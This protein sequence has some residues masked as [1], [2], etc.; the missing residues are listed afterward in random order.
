M[1]MYGN[2]PKTNNPVE[3]FEYLVQQRN[4]K[5]LP[6]EEQDALFS[7]PIPEESSS[8]LDFFA[9]MWDNITTKSKQA[10]EE[11]NA[12]MDEEA[13]R[14]AEEAALFRMESGIKESLAEPYRKPT[15]DLAEG[16]SLRPMMREDIVSL[17]EPEGDETLP[18]VEEITT[19]ELEPAEVGDSSSGVMARTGPSTRAVRDTEGRRTD[20]FYLDIGIHAESDH[21]ST[22]QITNDARE[23]D[24]PDEQKSRDIGFG[25]K[26]SADENA[27]GEIHGI[28]FKNEDGTFIPLTEKDKRYILK[29]DMLVHQKAARNAG[30]DTKLANIGTSWDELDS[31]YQNALTS[32]AYNVGGSKAGRTWTNVLTAAKNKDVSAFARG[33]RRK[34]AGRNTEGMDNR[35]AKELY[36]AGLIDSLADVSEELPLATSRNSGIPATAEED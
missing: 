35:V 8:T 5:A 32:L 7:K 17:G 6:K 12:I 1:S 15:S 23:A 13:L 9:D 24:L 14:S 2:L 18:S 34:D 25:H 3:L 4:N 11:A 21:G 26:I 16:T 28:K 30:W 19:T 20:Q 29:Q 10:R 36:Y 33:L 31:E 27:T 22:P